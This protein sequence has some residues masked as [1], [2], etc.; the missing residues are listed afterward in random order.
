MHFFCWQVGCARHGVAGPQGVP[1]G[2]AAP[3]TH[4]PRRH[5]CVLLQLGAPHGVKSGAT[6]SRH[7][8]LESHTATRHGALGGGHTTGRCTQPRASAQVG[9]FLL[10]RQGPLGVGQSPLRIGELVL[11]ELGQGQM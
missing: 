11:V 5:T 9:G 8:L 1:S 3:A 6:S 2:G 7:P 4:A 10:R